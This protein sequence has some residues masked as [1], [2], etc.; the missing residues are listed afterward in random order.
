MSVA[1]VLP[2]AAA[3]P[4]AQ[5]QPDCRHGVTLAWDTS[6]GVLASGYWLGGGSQAPSSDGAG[7]QPWRHMLPALLQHGSAMGVLLATHPSTDGT[8]V[9]LGAH[10]LPGACAS[11]Q[12]A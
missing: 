1:S 11:L 7:T 3:G 4:A 8:T 9:N 12:H 6:A 2:Q 10:V 5:A